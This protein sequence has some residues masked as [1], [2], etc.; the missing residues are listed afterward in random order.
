MNVMH[1]FTLTNET[2]YAQPMYKLQIGLRTALLSVVTS[3]LGEGDPWQ[4][5]ICRRTL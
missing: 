2:K 1:F 4:R 3:V 5:L